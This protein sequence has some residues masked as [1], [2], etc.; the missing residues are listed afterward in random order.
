MNLGVANFSIG[1]YLTD[2]VHRLL[3]LQGVSWLLPLD[4]EGS[5]HNMVACRD[6]LEEGFS[7]FGGDKDWGRHQ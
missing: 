1:D 6:V 3:D 2:E 7:L 5:A 4:D